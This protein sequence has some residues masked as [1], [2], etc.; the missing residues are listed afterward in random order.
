MQE[1]E[2]ESVHGGIAVNVSNPGSVWL[3][4]TSNFNLF[5][6]NDSTAAHQWGTGS[7]LSMKAWRNNTGGDVDSYLSFN[8]VLPADSL[9][10]DVAKGNLNINTNTNKC[11]YLNGKAIPY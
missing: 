10:T 1:Q 6:L 7:V 2:V 9:F 8:N 5:V 4:Q 11:W 3:P